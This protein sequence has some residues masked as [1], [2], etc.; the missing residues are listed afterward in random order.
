MITQQS[1]SRKSHN[2][3]YQ[4]KYAYQLQQ[5][6]KARHIKHTPLHNIIYANA[7]S[8]VFKEQYDQCGNSTE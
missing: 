5:S 1:Q 3:R 7:K 8:S 6:D 2:I 4:Q